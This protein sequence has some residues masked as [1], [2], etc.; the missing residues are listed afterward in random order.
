MAE[1]RKLTR[2]FATFLKSAKKQLFEYSSESP[3]PTVALLSNGDSASITYLLRPYL[4]K[5]GQQTVIV[6]MTADT[7]DGRTRVACSTVV[8]VRYLP[9]EWVEPL[10]AYRAS[11]GRVVYFMDDDLMDPQARRNLPALYGKKIHN[12][13]AR[14]RRTLESICSEFWVSTPYLARKYACW[15]PTLLPPGAEIGDIVPAT[16]TCSICYHGTASHKLE[17]EWL[18]PVLSDVQESNSTTRFEVFGDQHVNRMYR[19]MPRVAVLHPMSWSNYLAYTAATKHDIGLAPLL[20][21]PFNAARGPTK[22]F[23]FVRMGAVGIYSDVVP[24]RGFV[25]DGVDGLLLPN[26]PQL[27]VETILEL[28]NNSLQRKAMAEAARDRALSMA[29]KA[30]DLNSA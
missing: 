1:K 2:L 13:A 22:F 11:G 18:V 14:Q 6:D 15:S 10:R 25:R 5:L 23:D 20:P 9:D 24:Y 17:L 16:E 27:W 7:A 28:R 21:D 30:S 12:L 3:V 26:D 4:A 8:I 29:W 19:Q